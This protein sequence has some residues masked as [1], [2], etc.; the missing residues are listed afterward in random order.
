MMPD[1]YINVCED[2]IFNGHSDDA[3]SVAGAVRDGYIVRQSDGSFLVTVPCF[4]AKQKESFDEIAIAHLSPLMPEYSAIID[5]FVSEYKKLF[6]KHLTDDAD[7]MCHNMF[8]GM[9]A[10]VAEYAQMT[11]AVEM[12]SGNCF[13]DVML[14]R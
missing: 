1:F 6:P 12:P 9:Y 3:E 10:V 8:F 13:C 14:Q 7:R 11:N 4:A 2:I 5:S